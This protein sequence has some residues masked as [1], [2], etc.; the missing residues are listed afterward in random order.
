MRATAEEYAFHQ[1]ILDGDPIAFAELAEQLYV[2]LVRRSL[3][4]A[5]RTY[6]HA[7]PVL[8]EEAVG[9][10]LLDYNDHPERFDPHRSSLPEYLV[11]AAFRDFEN[12]HAKEARRTSPTVSIFGDAPLAETLEDSTQQQ[13][14]E[15]LP[16]D[17][18]ARD[19]LSGVVSAFTDPRERQIAMLIINQVRATEPYA[20]VLGIMNLSADE[21]ARE[22]K[23]VKDRIA[24]RMRRMGDSL[25]E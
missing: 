7:D 25:D 13:E 4:R 6:P 23:R 22:V 9:Q 18:R 10:A 14:I 12:L 15:E 19:L 17:L 20:Q 1:R 24:K 21:R 3:A 5:R 8:A 11:M 2:E 16:S